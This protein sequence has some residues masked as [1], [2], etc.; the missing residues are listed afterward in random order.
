[1]DSGPRVRVHANL[2]TP[3]VRDVTQHDDRQMTTRPDMH[4]VNPKRSASS[5]AQ[6]RWIAPR[7]RVAIARLES[8]RMARGHNTEP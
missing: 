4:D 8:R 3:R 2:T 7:E 1:M 6:R 5:P